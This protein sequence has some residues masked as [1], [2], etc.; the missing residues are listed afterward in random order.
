[1]VGYFCTGYINIVSDRR[2][3]KRKFC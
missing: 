3:W 2:Q 1:M